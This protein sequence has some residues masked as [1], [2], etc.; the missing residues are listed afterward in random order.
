MGA[1]AMRGG[2]YISTLVQNQVAII[3]LNPANT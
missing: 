1:G 3:R 2:F